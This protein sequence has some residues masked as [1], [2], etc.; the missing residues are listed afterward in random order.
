VLLNQPIEGKL[1]PIGDIGDQLILLMV[2][3]FLAGV[4]HALLAFMSLCPD[5]FQLYLTTIC[6]LPFGACQTRTPLWLRW[7]VTQGLGR[8]GMP[9]PELT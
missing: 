5:P 8:T 7:I 2:R 9:M 6:T 3:F 1:I 4:T